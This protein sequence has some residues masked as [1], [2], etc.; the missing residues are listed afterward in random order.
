[1]EYLTRTSKAYL[2]D[3]MGLGKTVQVAV[4]ARKIG[5]RAVL[6]ICPASLQAQWKKEWEKWNGTGFVNVMSYGSHSDL[7]TVL[8]VIEEYGKNP[9]DLCIL[10]EAHY[11]KNIRA[12]RT[13][14]A[15]EIA[16]KTPRAWLLSGTP[17]P[18]NPTELYPV[19]KH[20]WPEILEEYWISSEKAWRNYFCSWSTS[21]Y[22]GVRV[23]HVRNASTLSEMLH[24]IMLRR[25]LEDISLDLPELRNELVALGAKPNMP[26]AFFTFWDANM[27]AAVDS[28]PNEFMDLMRASFNAARMRRI[29]GQWK[30]PYIADIIDTEMES[31][32]DSHKIVI[33]AFHHDSLDIF[34]RMLKKYGLVDIRGGM[35]PQDRQQ[36]VD[37]FTN[38]PETR[39]FLGQQGACG[40]GMNLQVSH[41]IILAEPDWSPENNNQAIKRIHRIGTKRGCRARMFYVPD[42][43]DENIMK[44]LLTKLQ[45]KEAV[46][47]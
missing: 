39:V 37:Q 27:E 7:R 4:A 47:L 21:P 18:N 8:Q 45:M 22:Y 29:L 6:V 19:F 12:K 43:I 28:D 31:S 36:Y 23:T 9:Y 3:E 40:V 44:A 10:D 26:R 5:A 17:M 34:H 20:I 25:K 42:T 11:C 32:P 15:L 41:E 35:R 33:M 30:V 24:R 16:H 46:N 14:I 38:D 2:G 13:K 1:M